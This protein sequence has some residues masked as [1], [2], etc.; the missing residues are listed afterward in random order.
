MAF[1]KLT[2]SSSGSQ[3]TA[4]AEE[5]VS[6]MKPSPIFDIEFVT[7]SFGSTNLKHHLDQLKTASK[8]DLRQF[9]Q[10]IKHHGKSKKQQLAFTDVP[11]LTTHGALISAINHELRKRSFIYPVYRFILPIRKFLV[12]TFSG[13]DLKEHEYFGTLY[14]SRKYQKTFLH[15]PHRQLGQI[16]RSFCL[17]HWKF[18]IGT[19]LTI[20]TIILKLMGKL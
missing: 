17:A 7:S 20:V 1:Q 19:A 14:C 15:I 6:G 10:Q 9:R 4:P 16:V 18:I 5:Y 2:I 8:T 3:K 13:I 11:K 12:S